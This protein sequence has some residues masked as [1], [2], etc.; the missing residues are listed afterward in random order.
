MKGFTLIESVVAIFLLTVG[1]MGAVSLIQQSISFI[2]VSSSQLA[3]SYLAQEAI[4][5]VR[6]IRDTNY[7]ERAVWDEGIEEGADFRLDY[8]S[9]S[10]PDLSCGDYLKQEGDFY[11]CSPD[12]G[13]KFQRKITISKPQADKIIISIDVSWHERGREHHI[14]AE[15]E[16]YDWR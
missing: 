10:F 3:A 13:S 8:R 6:N 14:Y 15:T 4:E 12:S 7:L 11:I 2:T 5:T 1:T 16:L 9:Q